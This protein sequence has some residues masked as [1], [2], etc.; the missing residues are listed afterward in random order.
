MIC[1][2]AGPLGRTVEYPEFWYGLVSYGGQEIIIPPH[3]VEAVQ[4]NFPSM[5]ARWAHL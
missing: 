3:L 2:N 4:E 1:P 5:N